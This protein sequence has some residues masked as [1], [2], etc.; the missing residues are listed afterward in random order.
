MPEV[1]IVLLDDPGGQGELA[2][3]LYALIVVHEEGNESL[4][5]I[6]AP[7]GG[8]APAVVMSEA[9]MLKLFPW[10]QGLARAA[11]KTVQV[12][13]FDRGDVLEVFRP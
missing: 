13:R 2:E 5:G 4:A 6:P 1:P 7:L 8:V 3:H 9:T 11:G 12:I 10:A